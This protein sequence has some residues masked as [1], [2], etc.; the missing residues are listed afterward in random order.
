MMNTTEPLTAAFDAESNFI[1]YCYRVHSHTYTCIKYSLKGLAYHD[2]DKYRRTA[3]W[4]KVPRKIVDATGLSDTGLLTIH[5]KHP[6]VNRYNKAIAVGLRHNHD[7]SIILARIKGLAMVFYITNYATKLDTLIWRRIAH[8]AEVFRQLREDAV[9]SRQ[10]LMSVANR[11]FPERQLSAEEAG[12]ETEGEEPPETVQLREGGWTLLC[13][14]DYA[15]RGHALRGMCLYDYMSM[16]STIRNRGWDEDENHISLEGPPPE[17]HN[18]LQ[19]LRRPTERRAGFRR[20]ERLPGLD[21]FRALS[22]AT[23]FGVGRQAFHAAIRGL[24]SANP[25]RSGRSPMPCSD[26]V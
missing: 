21:E 17:C 26:P 8:A 15:Y 3:C 2:A 20:E 16:V 13:L 7:L 24:L 1:A 18:W 23:D 12:E 10:F 4:F 19:K 14:D 25:R 5:R 11:I 22:A 9:S 6:L